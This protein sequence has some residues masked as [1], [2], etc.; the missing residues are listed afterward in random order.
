[1]IALRSFAGVRVAPASSSA[2]AIRPA[3]ALRSIAAP[4]A[5]S[6]ARVSSSSASKSRRSPLKSLA[7]RAAAGSPP[8]FGAYGE[9][10]SL[11]ALLSPAAREATRSCPELG[12]N[13]RGL[14]LQRCRRCH[15]FCFFL[16]FDVNLISFSFSL[17]LNSPHSPPQAATPASRSSAS[18]A[19]A[20][21]PSTAWSTRA[22][23]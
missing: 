11:I 23:R 8:A 15:L 13:A 14:S 3:M 9:S 17:S 10:A 1:M 20:V 12:R 5:R 21:M 22:C 6:S 4:S 18:A 7:P 19:A 2:S 16:S